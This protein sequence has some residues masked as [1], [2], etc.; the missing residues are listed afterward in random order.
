M[1]R[2]EDSEVGAVRCS[3]ECFGAYWNTGNSQSV[4]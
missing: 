2:S 4:L 1:M 3:D